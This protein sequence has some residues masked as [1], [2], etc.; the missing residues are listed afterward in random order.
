MKRL[1]III[2]LFTL[3]I[4]AVDAQII[5]GALSAGINLTQVDGDEVYGF[6]KVGFNGGPSA[7]IPFAKRWSVSIETLFSQ[8]GSYQKTQEKD[9]LNPRYKLSLNYVEVPLLVHF[10][11]KKII[12]VGVGVSWCR[13]VGIKEWEYGRR[14]ESTTIDGPYKRNDFSV[15]ADVRIPIYKRLKIQ[16]RYSYT[17][18][19]IRK[20]PFYDGTNNWTRKQY[21][22]VITIRL[23]YIFNEKIL[24]KG[25]SEVR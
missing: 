22:N 16:A 8:K 10:E 7:I 1:F 19:Y 13:L 5:M 17:F 14:I 6:H 23:V 11:D 3:S 9:S 2:F 24:K 15:V 20:R 18:A 25:Y 21:N 4:A 12:C